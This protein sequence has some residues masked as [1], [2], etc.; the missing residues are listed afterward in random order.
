MGIAK[1]ALMNKPVNHLFETI[2]AAALVTLSQDASA[3]AWMLVLPAGTWHDRSGRG[4]FHIG[5]VAAMQAIID[6]TRAFMSGTELMVDFDHQ[7]E[8]L[9]KGKFGGRAEAAGWIKALE[10]RPDGI[11]AE[12]EWTEVAR[13]KIKAGSYRY[14]SPL[15]SADSEGNVGLIFNVALVN[16]PAI[17]LAAIAAS[18]N[19]TKE[20]VLMD[21]IALALG[22]KADAS[23]DAILAAA[24]A[25]ATALGTVA[26]A[27]GLEKTAK[28]EE[29]EGAITALKTD[30]GKIVT[31][32]GLDVSA[33][34]NDVVALAGKLKDAKPGEPDPTKWAPVSAMKA[35]QDQLN[36][37]ST[38]VTT[39]KATAKVDEAIKAG[40]LIP[41][42]RDWALT[43]AAKD[44]PA[45]ESYLENA[46][47]LTASQMANAGAAP[48]KVTITALSTEQK[49]VAD[50]LGQ[51]HDKYLA[52]LQAE[53]E[54]AN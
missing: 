25:L 31:A 54:A 47:A 48:P 27:A 32:L 15:F 34:T 51:P 36:A 14:I 20:N 6:R 30:T 26:L 1:L 13:A 9:I 8:P 10:A 2:A 19:L 24:T 16:M 45:F 11:W 39:D 7:L 42:Q 23:A 18:L 28:P 33:K 37:L 43:L 53:Q 4:P 49:K 44:M 41:A 52:T 3:R 12:I 17:D 29:I 50:L 38:T 21:K 5:D 35:L 22:L 40:K 46:V